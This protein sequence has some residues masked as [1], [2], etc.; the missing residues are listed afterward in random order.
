MNKSGQKD[1]SIQSSEIYNNNET[2]TKIYVFFMVTMIFTGIL[3]LNYRYYEDLQLNDIK[4]TD[5]DGHNDEFDA[6]KHDPT[7]WRDSDSDGYGDN[8]DVF[9][10]DPT[11]WEDSD[12]DGIG[13]NKDIF[14]NDGDNDGY[15]DD[16][17]LF[18]NGDA[19]IKL[20]LNAFRFTD[21]I[22]IR[23][24]TAA[25]L[26]FQV[27]YDWDSSSNDFTK[28]QN[29]LNEDGETWIVDQGV[30]FPVDVS[31]LFN[32]PDNEITYL[33][34]IFAMDSDLDDDD[35]IDINGVSLSDKGILLE[36][37]IL[38]QTWGGDDSDGV[39]AGSED[40][41][42][43][44]DD[45]DGIFYYNLSLVMIGYEKT[46]NWFYGGTYHVIDMNLNPSTYIEN[47]SKAR[48]PKDCQEYVNSEADYIIELSNKLYVS[49]E[50]RNYDYYEKVNYV[51]SFVQDIKYSYDNE[52]T[53]SDEYWRYPI[54]TLVDETGDCEDTSFLF[55]S[56]M[57]ALG[58]DAV[59]LEPPGHMGVGIYVEDFEGDNVT[60]EGRNYYFCETTG[61]GWEMGELPEDYEGETIKV[62]PV[63]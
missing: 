16:I 37:D 2:V 41:S 36:Y 55:A 44:S 56:L 57:E 29:I 48:L 46:Y 19:A 8:K 15:E 30:Y 28:M 12:K 42:Q 13:D 6:F 49:A 9:P 27:Q 25:E 63:E 62:Y 39:A 5:C 22:D 59:C 1:E 23:P 58:Y 40:G 32:A 43:Y 35:I 61:N 14:P 60:Y 21:P 26:Y 24:A 11:E 45:D 54:E 47:R 31:F 33:I 53:R 3:A 50:F 7:E 4:D 18:P 51:L 20:E 52:T 38:T 10:N 17:D 34:N